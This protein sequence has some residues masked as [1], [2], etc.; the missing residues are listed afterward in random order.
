MNLQNIILIK[1]LSTIFL[2]QTK[3]KDFKL[4]IT[5]QRRKSMNILL[6]HYQGNIIYSYGRSDLIPTQQN[7]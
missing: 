7:S 1:I 3:K 6:I 2:F 5:Y 4:C